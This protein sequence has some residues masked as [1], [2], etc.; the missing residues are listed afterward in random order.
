MHSMQQRQMATAR[1]AQRQRPRMAALWLILATIFAHAL[2]PVGSPL[3]RNSGS[4]FSATTPDVS[5]VPARGG[6][7]A[8][9]AREDGGSSASL[10]GSDP[11]HSPA[12]T[13][14]APAAGFASARAAAPPPAAPALRPRPASTQPYAARAPPLS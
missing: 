13:L 1:E 11:P 14:L 9:L 4:A 10:G 5:L 7:S 6:A 2:L 8:V 3:S 12:A